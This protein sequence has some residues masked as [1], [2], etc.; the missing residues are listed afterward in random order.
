[1]LDIFGGHVSRD[2][3]IPGFALTYPS[4]IDYVINKAILLSRLQ[5]VKSVLFS[6]DVVWSHEVIVVSVLLEVQSKLRM[7][8]VLRYHWVL[9]VV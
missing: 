1:M 9:V 5:N 7:K 4:W 3:N 8:Q 2:V 6:V